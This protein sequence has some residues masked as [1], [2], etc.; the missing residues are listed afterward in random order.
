MPGT[1]LGA[2]SPK[3][4]AQLRMRQNPAAGLSAK[5]LVEGHNLEE[6]K[7]LARDLDVLMPKRQTKKALAKLIVEA[8]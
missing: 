8:S 1:T 6:L 5:D 7:Q 4:A 2:N 3:R